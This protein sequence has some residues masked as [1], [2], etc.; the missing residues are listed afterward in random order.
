MANRTKAI[1]LKVLIRKMRQDFDFFMVFLFAKPE[2]VS[3]DNNVGH[4]DY[5]L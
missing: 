4:D 1:R 3:N 5:N 2:V